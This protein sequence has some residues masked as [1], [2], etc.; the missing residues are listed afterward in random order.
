MLG[1]LALGFWKEA[2]GYQPHI[3]YIVEYSKQNPRHAV[4]QF[5]FFFLSRRSVGVPTRPHLQ[6]NARAQIALSR[7]QKKT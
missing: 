6:G 4:T 1:A 5:G 7:S 2:P 3:I